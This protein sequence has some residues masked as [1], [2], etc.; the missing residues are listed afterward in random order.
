MAIRD[1]NGELVR[2]GDV[3]TFSFGIP[4][5]GVRAEVIRR[6]GKLIALTPGHNPKE[7]ALDELKGHVGSFYLEERTN[8]SVA[9][10]LRSWAN[11]RHSIHVYG[12]AVSLLE[13]QDGYT[14]EKIVHQI[15][16][17]TVMAW[18]EAERTGLNRA[19]ALLDPLV[20]DGLKACRHG[21]T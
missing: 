20:L 13:A 21:R 8:P 10:F 2:E 5:K 16:L 6:D 11:D 1:S 17:H 15:V 14:P 4:P 9:D 12:K 19:S 3:V 18:L 7:C